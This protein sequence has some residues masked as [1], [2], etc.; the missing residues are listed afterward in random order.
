MQYIKPD[1]YDTFSCIGGVCPDTCCAGWEIEIDEGTLYQYKN[2]APSVHTDLSNRFKSEINYDESVFCQKSNGRCAFLNDENLC[3]IYKNTQ[4]EML[5]CDT[6]RNY[7]RHIEEFEGIREISIGLS[8]PEAARI[9]L[10]NPGKVGFITEEDELFEEY[11]DFDY[12]LYSKLCDLRSFL[13]ETAQQRNMPVDKRIALLLDS[14]KKAQEAVDADNLFA[15]D[16]IILCQGSSCPPLNFYEMSRRYFDVLDSLEILR[17]S[18]QK[19]RD[20][21][22]EILFSK[23]EEGYYTLKAGFDS[24]LVKSGLKS[25]FDT[26]LEQILVYFIFIY[27]CGSVYD[28]LPYAKTVFAV[29]SCII[30]SD[31]CMARYAK[32][33]N[34]QMSDI[35]DIAHS[36]AREVEHSNENLDYIDSNIA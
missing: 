11:D 20:T 7:P 3:D 32:E 34:L 21:Y 25:S 6:C 23:N 4:D 18:W 2:Y 15:I 28:C 9:I 22:E 8:C 24:Y 5:W 31:L 26:A 29:S 12:L 13:I 36:Y 27:F 1:Y 14:S 33:G 16:D 17:E 10:T 19:M 35:I 30:I